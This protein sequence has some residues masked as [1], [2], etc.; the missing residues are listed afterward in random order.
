MCDSLDYEAQLRQ[1]ISFL[2]GCKME[3]DL[4]GHSQ[5]PCFILSK[6]DTKYFMK[7]Y[8]GNRIDELKYIESIYKVLR[9]PTAF[10]VKIGYLQKTNRTFCIYD[11]IEGDTLDE[12]L[13]QV[14]S[15][16]AEEFGVKIGGEL[17]KFADLEGD[18]S[19]F[20][21]AFNREL[22]QLLELAHLQKMSYNQQHA[23]LLPE[24]DLHRL[25]KS[26]QNL[27][28]ALYA[29]TPI[30]VHS[31]LNLSNI[32]INRG[33]PYFIDTEGSQINFRAF[34]FRGNCWWCWSGSD[35]K[36]E[37]AIYRGIYRGTFHDQIPA[38][39]HQELSFM[40]TYQ[41]LH[42]VKK[43]ANDETQVHYSFLHWRDLLAQTNYFEN[44]KFDWF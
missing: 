43:Y 37:Q 18:S 23:E 7:V 41:F 6:A 40:V 42:R 14:P 32:I 17:R 20:K 8:P 12:W 27:K 19:K 21:R 9:I 35:I 2:Q 30:F 31:D 25:K 10:I 1:E 16:Q 22:K 11:F 34:N 38:S 28:A 15:A 39:F 5:V 44:Y 29:T 4:R 33:E 3:R 36:K 26:L 24:I 13:P